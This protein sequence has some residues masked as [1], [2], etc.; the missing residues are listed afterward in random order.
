VVHLFKLAKA[1]LLDSMRDFNGIF[2]PFVFPLFLFFVL[3][4]VF[5]SADSSNMN[6]NFNL[7]VV[8]E[9]RLSGFGGFLN[10]LLTAIQPEP[11]QLREYDTWEKALEDLKKKKLDV[12][13]KIP[14]GFSGRLTW[15]VLTKQSRNPPE[16][17]VHCLEGQQESEMAAQLLQMILEQA[18]LEFFKRTDAVGSYVEAQVQQ[19][20]LSVVEESEFH[21]PTYLFPAVI[22][23]SWLA[24]CL[25]NLPL[26][27]SYSREAGI[28][29]RFFTCGVKPFEYFTS[30][31]LSMGVIMVISCVLIY[32]FGM[33]VYRV[34]PSCL[35]LE[36]ILKLLFTMMVFF[37]LGMMITAL[38][39]KSS[40]ALVVSQ[41][42]NQILMFLGGF[43]F[44][45]LNF[46]LPKPLK[47]FC[48]ALPTTY[49]VEE[50]RKSL[51]QN[52]YSFSMPQTFLVP[53]VW[54]VLALVLFV[55]NFKR[56]MG[57]E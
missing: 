33:L 10:Q 1:F 16:L 20:P 43:Y 35:S 29:K 25:F 26:S 56:V 41:I 23:M 15:A 14:S 52:V 50:L 18:N 8:F 40:S 17:E 49:L 44:P 45:L 6:V 4:S 27:I 38:F 57:Y 47:W 34:Q 46:G 9:E 55:A 11:F 31:L 30:L 21:Y 53:S 24:I 32:V 7:G 19:R 39:R 28:N 42:M 54:F 5:S 37:S 36:F 51:G 12:V 22:L 48:L 3:T 2:W 13:L